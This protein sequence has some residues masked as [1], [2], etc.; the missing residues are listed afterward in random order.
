MKRRLFMLRTLAFL[1]SSVMA[2]AYAGE[3]LDGSGTAAAPYL[4]RTADDL[5]KIDEAPDACYRLVNVIELADD[6]TPLCSETPFN[7]V[8]DGKG[9]AISGLSVVG[10]RRA[11]LFAQVGARGRIE[12]LRLSGKVVASASTRAAG[13][14]AGVFS[15]V[16]TGITAKVEI[17]VDASVE[18]EVAVGGIVGINSGVVAFSGFEGS[19]SDARGALVSGAIVGRTE[20]TDELRSGIPRLFTAHAGF[21]APGGARDTSEDNTLAN[22]VK[23]L[24]YRPDVVEVD[25]RTVEGQGLVISHNAPKKGEKAP[26]LETVL[27]ILMG[28]TPPEFEGEEFDPEV[29]RR[30]KIQLDAKQDGLF[31][32]EFELLDKLGFPYD[33]VLMAG[34]ARYE[35]VLANIERIRVAVEKG[36][37]FWMNPDRLDSYA[38][39]A[40]RSDAFLEKIRALDLPTFTVNSSYAAITPEVEEWLRANNLRISMWTLNNDGAIR[41]SLLRG[42]YN[43]TSRLPEALRTREECQR[44]GVS[45]NE[46]DRE[47]YQEVG[48]ELQ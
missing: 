40:A 2:T 29:A 46:F 25:V 17:E 1:A 24:R 14:L 16:A 35:T 34:D 18:R 33:R 30:T 32:E 38:S 27:R 45:H 9:R 22:I 41:Q 10:G 36:M 3:T 6:W 13:G 37:E 12:N 4:V 28:E 11:G 31:L 15:G 5:R 8:L 7:G 20:K 26:T 23:A 19:I 21:A 47:K 48:D 42:A 44:R 43:V 39:L